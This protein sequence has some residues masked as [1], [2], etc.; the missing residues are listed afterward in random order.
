MLKHWIVSIILLKIEIKQSELNNKLLVTV[1]TRKGA[2]GGSS[3]LPLQ[4]SNS[5]NEVIA[6]L[7]QTIF[8]LN[9]LTFY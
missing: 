1:T 9:S 2:I 4:R 6:D 5:I 7:L 3:I 8:M